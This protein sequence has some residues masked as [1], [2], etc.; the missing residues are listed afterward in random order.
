MNSGGSYE[1][2]YSPG[3]R[4]DLHKLP[5]GALRRIDPKILALAQEPRPPGCKKLVGSIDM[6]RI[7]VGDYRVVYRIDDRRRQV[8]LTIV[9]NRRESYRGM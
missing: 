7:R 1:I 6:Y 2:L 8:T 5:P 4:R 3:A 9:A